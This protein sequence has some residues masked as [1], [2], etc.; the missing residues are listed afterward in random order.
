VRDDDDDDDDEDPATE[1]PALHGEAALAAAIISRAIADAV[2]L[3]TSVRDRALAHAFLQP[4]DDLFCFWCH[5]A[6]AR[7]A[8][9]ATA[10]AQQMCGRT[11]RPGHPE[12]AVLHGAHPAVRGVLRRLRPAPRV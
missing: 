10:V 9:V 1:D 12:R 11:R 3:E 7:P 8:V 4:S 2:A 5:L 6:G